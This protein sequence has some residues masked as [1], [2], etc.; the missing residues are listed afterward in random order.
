MHT[1]IAM[2]VFRSNHLLPNCD[3]VKWGESQESY[4][5][6]EILQLVLYRCASKHPPMVGTERGAANTSLR[7]GISDVVTLVKHYSLPI[8][9]EKG[10]ARCSPPLLSRFPSS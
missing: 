9:L 1:L 10:S 3:I 5:T 7:F 6:V 8:Q 2:S 4:Q